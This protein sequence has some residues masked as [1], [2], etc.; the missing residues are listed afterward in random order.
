M[1]RTPIIEGNVPLPATAGK[2]V[3]SSTLANRIM[4]K[5]CPYCDDGHM[6]PVEL[7]GSEPSRAEKAWQCD[8]CG[9]KMYKAK[10]RTEFPDETIERMRDGHEGT[11]DSCTDFTYVVKTPWL[12][13]RK[14]FEYMCSDCI[15]ATAEGKKK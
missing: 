9:R 7:T 5:N 15:A 12:R 10:V 4:K 14:I 13:L 8:K 2:N 6:Q 11:C 3:A 1:N